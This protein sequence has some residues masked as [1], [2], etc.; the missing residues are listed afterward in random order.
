M[1]DAFD[2]TYDELDEYIRQQ[3]PDAQHR[4]YLWQTGIG[5]QAVDGLTTSEYLIQT[6]KQNID[7]DITLAEAQELIHSYYESR[8][9]RAEVEARTEEADKVSARIAQ[10]LAEDTFVFAPT[11]LTSIHQRLFD[12]IFDFAGQIRDYNITKREWVLGGESVTYAGADMIVATLDYDFAQEK[13][14]SYRGLSRLDTI[15]HLTIFVANLW[16]IHPFG[17]G[18]TRTT[19]VFTIKYLRSMGFDVMNTLF[20]ENSWYFR[21]ALVR[22][23]YTDITRGVYEN[24]SYLEAFFRNLLLGEDNELR[25]RNLYIGTATSQGGGDCGIN[26]GINVGINQTEQSVLDL[27]SANPRMTLSAA[28][29]TLDLGERQVQRIASGLQKK[30]LLERLGSRKNGT[31]HVI[32]D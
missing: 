22:A 16:Q 13:A 14:F 19:A 10:L 7:G 27:L 20:A 28:A 2:K 18:N 26:V 32:G 25:N 31:W 17:E 30:G 5:L 9:S 3:E 11:Q 1:S 8:K 23:N 4:G 21:N 6:A 24:P 29:D 15:K 12:G